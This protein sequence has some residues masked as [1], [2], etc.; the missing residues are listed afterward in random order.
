MPARVV[1]VHDECEFVGEVA[2][3]LRSAGHDVATFTDLLAAWDALKAVQ[4][5]EVLVTRMQFAPAYQTAWPWHG[6]RA[7]TG[8]TSAFCLRRGQSSPPRRRGWAHSYLCR[9]PSLMQ[10]KRGT[11]CSPRKT[12]QRS[13]LPATPYL[14]A[15]DGRRKVQMGL[16]QHL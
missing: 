8:P 16:K 3:A 15:V 9:P 13:D 10:W 11:A 1:V 7:S 2:T 14:Y 4:K 12:V 5:T 6:R